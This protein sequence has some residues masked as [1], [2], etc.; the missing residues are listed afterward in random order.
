VRRKTQERDRSYVDG[1][2][3]ARQLI[4]R[5]DEHAIT[6]E[7]RVQMLELVRVHAAREVGEVLMVEAAICRLLHDLLGL[8][9]EAKVLLGECVLKR[10]QFEAH[11]ALVLVVRIRPVRRV[12]EDHQ[13]LHVREVLRDTLRRKGIEDVV[14]RCFSRH[15]VRAGAASQVRRLHRGREMPAIPAHPA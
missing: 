10:Q 11:R 5:D 13:E 12:P 7:Q 1:R 2:R 8:A 4:A 9:I 15:R 6:R 14:R 3:I